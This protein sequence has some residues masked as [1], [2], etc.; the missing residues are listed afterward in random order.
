MNPVKLSTFDIEGNKTGEIELSSEVFGLDVKPEILHL[1]VVNYLSSQRKGTASTK[2]RA[3]VR[4]GGRKPW[5]QKGTGRAR[6]GSIRSP[7]WVGGGIIFGPKP[8]NY[9]YSIPKKVKR[10]AIKGA[11]SSKVKNGEF[12]VLDEFKLKEPKTK[13]LVKILGNFKVKKPLLLIDENDGIL[14]RIARNI[15]NVKVYSPLQINTYALLNCDKIITTK[16]AVL[17]IQGLFK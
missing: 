3:E 10:L 9:S 1:S 4:G 2:T 6:A 11:L 7:L 8:R 13:E 15:K 17:K 12:V 16:D 14:K 5:R